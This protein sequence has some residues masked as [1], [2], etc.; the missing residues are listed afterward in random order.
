[1]SV[2]EYIYIPSIYFTISMQ[3]N[4]LQ[5][6]SCIKPYYYYLVIEKR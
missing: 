1:M 2:P 3:D 4:L 5:L 6:Y